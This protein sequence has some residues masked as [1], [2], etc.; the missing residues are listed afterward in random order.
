MSQPIDYARYNYRI[1]SSH[2]RYKRRIKA[3]PRKLICQ[4]C[5]GAGSFHEPIL[6][7]GTGPSYECG[8]CQ[9]TGYVTGWLRG[10]WLRYRREQAA[11]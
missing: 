7:D 10:Q 5:R 6:D 3:M 2:Q 4:E 8:W 9:G 11:P 1:Q